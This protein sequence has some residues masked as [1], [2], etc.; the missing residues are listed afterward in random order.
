MTRARIY[1][2]SSWRNQYQPALVETL[3]TAGHQVYDFRNPVPGGKGFGWSQ[4]GLGDWRDYTPAIARDALQHPVAQAGFKS[5]HDAMEWADTF[6]M[7]LPCGRSAH[8]E[9]G[10]ACGAK[11]RTFILQLEQQE[12]ELMYLEANQIC[13]S[14]DELLAALAAPGGPS[15]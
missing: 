14:V 9:L 3:R 5:D 8:L 13:L 15:T 7:A 4:L 11:K 12:P 2:A 6:V 1:L 10:W